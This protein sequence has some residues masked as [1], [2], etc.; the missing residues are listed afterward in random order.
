MVLQQIERL[1][2][3]KSKRDNERIFIQITFTTIN[4]I[5]EPGK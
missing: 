1:R 3:K 4:L 2:G 5:L